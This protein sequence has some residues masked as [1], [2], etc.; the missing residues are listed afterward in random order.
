MVAA[1][2]FGLPKGSVAGHIAYI[3]LGANPDIVAHDPSAGELAEMAAR[4]SKRLLHMHDPDWGFSARR[5]VPDTR[6]KGDFDQLARYGEWD[7]T[8]LPLIIPLG[9]GGDA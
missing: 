5:A 3:G 4:L 2:C 9:Q 7:E 6:F 1:G 8:D